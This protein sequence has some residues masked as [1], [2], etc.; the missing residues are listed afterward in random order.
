M[1]IDRLENSALY[2]ALG[3]RIAK[4]L[5]YLRSTDFAVL[6][7]GEYPVDGR[8]IF[9]IVNDYML[10]PESQGRLEA[11]RRYIDIQ[12]L[13]RGAEQIGYAPFCG[14]QETTAF[15]DKADVGFYSGSAS[16]TRV[17]EGMFAIYYPGDLHMPGIGDPANSVRKVVVKIRA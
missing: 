16:L 12:Y 5:E 17:E 10:K 8:D 9:A 15:D 13:A 4:G 3:A 6:E 1:V 2:E 14:Q 11:H 7:P